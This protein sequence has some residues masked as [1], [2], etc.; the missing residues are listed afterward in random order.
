MRKCKRD[1]ELDEMR[2]MEMGL[3]ARCAARRRHGD[4][5]LRRREQEREAKEKKTEEEEVGAERRESAPHGRGSRVACSCVRGSNWGGWE[6]HDNRGWLD[7]AVERRA[8]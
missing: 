2:W 6:Q 8:G 7:E 4:G 1:G 3:E 5:E